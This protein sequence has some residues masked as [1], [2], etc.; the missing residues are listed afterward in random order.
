MRNCLSIK[1]EADSS[2][3]LHSVLYLNLNLRRMQ[4]TAATTGL[5]IRNPF[6]EGLD[7]SP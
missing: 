1:F 3:A 5:I 2:L 7:S 4:E 6:C